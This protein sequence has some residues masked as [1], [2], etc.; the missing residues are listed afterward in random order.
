MTSTKKQKMD[1]S[2]AIVESFYSM[3]PPG[4][5]LKKCPDTCQWNELSKKD[6]VDRVALAMAYDVR[7]KERSKR[8]REEQRRRSRSSSRQKSQDEAGADSSQS[9]DRP[10][11]HLHATNNQLEGNGL[12]SA[13]HGL[14]APR[15]GEVAGTTNNMQSAGE[16][17]SGNSNLLQQQLL[18]QLLQSSTTTTLPSSP[19]NPIDQN[20]LAQLISQALQHQQLQQQL[21]L[22]YGLNSL[23][24]QTQTPLQPTSFEGLTQMLAQAQQQQQQQEQLVLFQC[25]LNQQNVLSSDSLPPAPS[26]S[27]PSLTGYQSRPDNNFVLQ[28]QVQ[29][30]SHPSND[31]LL[32]SVLS[33]LQSQQNSNIGISN[34]PQGAQQMDQ[35]QR[36]LMLQQQQLLA[37]SLGA[38][39]QLPLRQQQPRPFDPLFQQAFQA[40]LQLQQNLQTG[41]PPPPINV[42]A[43]ASPN[44]AAQSSRQEGSED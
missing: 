36:S 28:N 12:L 3:E 40:A 13:A 33:N 11:L 26:L 10:Q 14:V 8:K 43:L 27:A 17:L 21:P 23:G 16:L 5:F 7:G 18:Q 19:G 6:A 31:L 35:F 22:Q 41:H 1:M 30:Q 24:L 2:N 20:G 9:A 37:S 42:A 34:A 29:P 32:S 39:N 15:R 38:S 4:R 44:F 25:L